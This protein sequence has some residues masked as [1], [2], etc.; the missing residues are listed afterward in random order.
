[1]V[2]ALC[3]GGLVVGWLVGVAVVTSVG[4]SVGLV[5]GLVVHFMVLLVFGGVGCTLRWCFIV[6]FCVV[7]RFNFRY[8]VMFALC[9]RGWLV[10]W[11]GY[12]FLFWVE[13]GVCGWF[14]CFCSLLFCWLLVRL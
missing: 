1:M 7:G 8:V 13:V 14:V 12:V 4:L 9:Y 10:V 6:G 11:V 5:C 3:G 2:A